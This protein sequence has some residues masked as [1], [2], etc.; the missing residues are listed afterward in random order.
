MS[1]IFT[2]FLFSICFLVSSEENSVDVQYE[3]KDFVYLDNAYANL[4]KDFHKELILRNQDCIYLETC[5]DTKTKNLGE[6]L[7]QKKANQLYK[8]TYKEQP[9]YPRR[10]KEEFI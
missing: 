10:A 3:D 5:R 8:P 4:L 7:Y 1:K 9:K 2:Y 6:K